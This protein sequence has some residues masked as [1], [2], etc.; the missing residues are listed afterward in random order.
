MIKWKQVDLPA[1]STN[2]ATG[3]N[4]SL[5]REEWPSW[6]QAQPQF[7]AGWLFPLDGVAAPST[8]A[9][10][11]GNVQACVN[12]E[13]IASSTSADLR[14]YRY[15]YARTMDGRT[16]QSEPLKNLEYGHH[17]NERPTWFAS[18]APST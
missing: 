11:T 9:L 8:A 12:F 13:R 17:R 18:T 16:F 4:Q 3:P 14:Y 10:S 6:T 2:R 7:S 1:L 15:L 5:S